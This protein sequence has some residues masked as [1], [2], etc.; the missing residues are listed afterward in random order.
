MGNAVDKKYE[1]IINDYNI[2]KA[3]KAEFARIKE[4]A[5]HNSYLNEIRKNRE[6]YERI[7]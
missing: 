4:E 1:K 2:K 3:M 6:K 7:T 5:N